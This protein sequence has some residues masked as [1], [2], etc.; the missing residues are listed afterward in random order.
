MPGNYKFRQLFSIRIYLDSVLLFFI[1]LIVSFSVKPTIKNKK[2]RFFSFEVAKK[3]DL[4]QSLDFFLKSRKIKPSFIELF[5]VKLSKEGSFL[6]AYI[7]QALL[8]AK[9]I[10]LE[11]NKF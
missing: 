1:M 9:K 4:T 3:E 5:H 10:A 6:D 11:I 7:A 2:S 8:K